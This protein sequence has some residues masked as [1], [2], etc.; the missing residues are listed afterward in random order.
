[1]PQSVAITAVI[2]I[3]SLLFFVRNTSVDQLG[4]DVR[5]ALKD[6]CWLR[7]IPGFVQNCDALRISRHWVKSPVTHQSRERSTASV[8]RRKPLVEILREGPSPADFDRLQS[9]VE[10]AKVCLLQRANADAARVGTLRFAHPTL[11]RFHRD[12]A[13]WPSRRISNRTF[14]SGSRPTTLPLE[15]TSVDDRPNDAPA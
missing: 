13:Y 9:R 12:V 3:S 11:R 6:R 2:F 8:L 10:W 1:M 4:N 5:D 7:D 14:T 15:T